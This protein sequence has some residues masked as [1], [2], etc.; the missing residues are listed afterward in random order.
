M[1]R[2]AVRFGYEIVRLPDGPVIAE[3]ETGHVVTDHTGRVIS[4]P[5]VYRRLL[6]SKPLTPLA[7]V[8]PRAGRVP[9]EE[10]P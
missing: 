4:M 7:A 5:E 9:E 6:N 1:R 2:R 3:G 8:P 10:A